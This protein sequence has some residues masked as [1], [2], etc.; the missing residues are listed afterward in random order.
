MNDGH[1]SS[2]YIIHDVPFIV[3]FSLQ[4]AGPQVSVVRGASGCFGAFWVHR[5][6]RCVGLTMV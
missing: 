1:L 4:L 6:L 5:Y 2:F 3:L